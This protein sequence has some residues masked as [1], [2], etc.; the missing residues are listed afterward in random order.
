MKVASVV[1]N[2]TFI[3]TIHNYSFGNLSNEICA[4][5]LKD[6]RPFSH[7]IEKWIEANYPLT[8]INGCKDH[9]FID[10]NNSEIKYDEKTFTC[11]GCAFVPSNMLGQGRVFNKEVFEEKAKKLIYCIVSNVNFPEIKI[12]FVSGTE[13]I[14][15]YPNGKIPLKDH[16]KLFEK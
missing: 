11:K 12:K 4:K 13:L 2:R 16:N 6:G 8:H 1:L 9:D 15:A 10:R 5:I 3:H 7:F 14:K